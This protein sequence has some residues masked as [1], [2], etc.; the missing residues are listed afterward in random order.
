MSREPEST[1]FAVDLPAFTGPFRVLA[2][3][4]LEQKVD[5]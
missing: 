3:L 2:E 1:G 5:V 4:I